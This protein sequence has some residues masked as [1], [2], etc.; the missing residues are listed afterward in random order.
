MYREKPRSINEYSFLFSKRN[1]AAAS[2]AFRL[3]LLQIQRARNKIQQAV[4]QHRF[5]LVNGDR[6]KPSICFSGNDRGIESRPVRFT[7]R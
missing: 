4:D 7:V 1:G 5:I 2:H 3:E 6:D